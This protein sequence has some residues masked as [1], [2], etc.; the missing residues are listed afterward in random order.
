[1]SPQLF[2]Q[3]YFLTPPYPSAMELVMGFDQSIGPRNW[4]AGWVNQV[5]SL[6][7]KYPNIQIDFVVF[8]NMKVPSQVQSMNQFFNAIGHGQHSSFGYFQYEREYYGN[9]QAE[10]HAFKSILDQYQ[11]K[12]MLDVTQRNYFPGQ[13]LPIFN[14]AE[15]PYFQSSDSTIASIYSAVLP[16]EIGRAFGEYAGARFP[17]TCTLPSNPNIP[18]SSPCN[19]WNQQIVRAIVDDSLRVQAQ[20]RQFTFFDAGYP[21]NFAP[22]WGNPTFRSWIWSDPNYAANYALSTSNALTPSQ[23]SPPTVPPT[24]RTVNAHISSPHPAIGSWPKVT[25]SGLPQS[26]NVKEVIFNVNTHK[27]VAILFPGHASSNGSF[28]FGFRIT[29]SMVG[30]DSISIYSPSASS[31]PVVTGLIFTVS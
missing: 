27:I 5:A 31:T 26:S 23:S 16:N 11:M 1:M 12:I 25:L 4:M 14:Y 2:F 29:S 20:N 15:F 28:S 17:A 19:G 8:V 9:T 24:P 3:N 18:P 22:F 21:S 7:D 30:S 13:N 6:A 10:V